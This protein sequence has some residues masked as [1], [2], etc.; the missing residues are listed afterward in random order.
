VAA[1]SERAL[2]GCR[3]LVGSF[4]QS[5]A[6]PTSADRGEARRSRD[7]GGQ[8]QRSVSARR[9]RMAPGSAASSPCR[10]C[11]RWLQ[12]AGSRRSGRTWGGIVA[13]PIRHRQAPPHWKLAWPVS[14]RAGGRRHGPA[15]P[16]AATEPAE[17]AT[18]WV[19]EEALSD[20]L[21]YQNEPRARGL[22]ARRN[23]PCG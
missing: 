13:A 18:K 8:L 23:R 11:A 7:G 3:A 4:V 1:V 14:R 22:A 20:P 6:G 2:I 9:S 19:G 15:V 16:D 21:Q 5:A 10:T 17:P 12:R